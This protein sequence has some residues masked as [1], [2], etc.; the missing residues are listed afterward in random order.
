MTEK[1]AKDISRQLLEGLKTMHEDVFCHRDLKPQN[2]F[3][4]S[5]SPLVV[6]ISEFGV[7]KRA[8]DSTAF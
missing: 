8:V 7:S 2:I 6:E 1:Q 5:L 4:T 3:V